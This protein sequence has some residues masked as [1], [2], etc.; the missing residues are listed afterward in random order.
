MSHINKQG[1]VRS[2]SLFKETLKLYKLVWDLNWLIS[3]KHVPGS[4]NILA[5]LLSRKG[6]VIQTDWELHQ[7]AAKQVFQL[8]GKLNIDLFA[9]KFNNKLPIYVSPIPDPAAL[10]V[11]A[12]SISWEKMFAYAFPPYRLLPQVLAKVSKTFRICLILIA[13]LWERQVLLKDIRK[14]AV[15]GPYPLLNWPTLL[16]WQRWD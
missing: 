4:L 1:G 6:Q 9:M 12:P 7:E 8:W 2:W 13:P 5:D 16:R 14:M 10:E 3:A 11:N 15:D